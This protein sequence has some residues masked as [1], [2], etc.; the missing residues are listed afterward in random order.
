MKLV[1]AIIQPQ[2]PAKAGVQALWE[3]LRDAD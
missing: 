1:T 2:R 3:F